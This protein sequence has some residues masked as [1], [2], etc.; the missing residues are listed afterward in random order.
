MN[1]KKT[2]QFNSFKQPTPKKI[3]LPLKRVTAFLLVCRIALPVLAENNDDE[4]GV[5]T[6]KN[7]ANSN[8]TAARKTNR[9][10]MFYRDSY[11]VPTEFAINGNWKVAKENIDKFFSLSNQ[12]L[13]HLHQGVKDKQIAQWSV[14]KPL[15][16]SGA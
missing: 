13:F 12:L 9:H 5:P 4:N 11:S 6:P 8:T 10:S 2:N 7:N 3:S 16:H 14:V 15:V 1:T